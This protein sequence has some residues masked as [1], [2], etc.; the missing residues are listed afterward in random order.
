[1]TACDS[2]A[3]RT[4]TIGRMRVLSIQSAVAFGHVGNSAAVFPLQR[5]GHEVWPVYTVQFSNHTGY[6]SWRGR[7]APA[8][9]VREVIEGVDDRGELARVDVVL[10]G[11]VGDPAVVDV[12]VD[13]VRRVK[14]LNPSARFVCDPVMGSAETGCFVDP[15][16]PAILR[17]QA[18][19][20]ADVVL[21]NQFELGYL[22]DSEPTTRAE[23]VESIRALQDQG[24]KTVVVT[25]VQ[26]E[27]TPDSGVEVVVA[28]GGDVWSVE[29]PWLPMTVNGSGD[30]L[31]A[32]FV[33][34]LGNTGSVP[35]ALRRA[36]SGVF[37]VL[38]ATRASGEREIQ[39]V[40]AQ[41]EFVH[42]RRELTVTRI[43]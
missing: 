10:S 1:M 27:T 14:E 11:Y 21:P 18:I 39:L 41:E 37:G 6:G 24:P 19:P 22:T 25:S 16:I 34:Q 7:V 17:S 29:T 26:T 8:A 33:G 13:A 23:L 35:E 5:L 42:P 43:A 38:E 2:S 3:D 4:A 36:T 15:A 40:A 31:S 20:S 32:L 30:L 9:E 28:D 12:V